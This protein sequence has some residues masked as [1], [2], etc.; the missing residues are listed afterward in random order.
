MAVEVWE[1]GADQERWMAATLGP[2]L[3]QAGAAASRRIEW[4]QLLG[5]HT[6]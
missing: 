2:A 3:G 4:L 1:T 5:H 6:T